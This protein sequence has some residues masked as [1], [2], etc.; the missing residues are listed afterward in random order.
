MLHKTAFLVP[1]DIDC[2]SRNSS[3]L[4]TGTAALVGYIMFPMHAT[5]MYKVTRLRPYHGAINKSHATNNKEQANN[6]ATGKK[7]PSGRLRG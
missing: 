7:N 1:R 4:V 2:C 6:I 5:W 3:L